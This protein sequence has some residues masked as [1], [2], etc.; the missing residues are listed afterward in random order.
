MWTCYLSNHCYAQLPGH[1]AS[2]TRGEVLKYKP[3]SARTGLVSILSPVSIGQL[4]IRAIYLPLM[5]AG[6][7]FL[8]W[9]GKA[10]GPGFQQWNTF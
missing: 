4:E 7:H 10:R 5:Q 3:R 9:Q 1:T 6:R 8:G 2:P